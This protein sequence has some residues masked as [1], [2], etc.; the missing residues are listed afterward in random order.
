MILAALLLV[1]APAPDR[2]GWESGP[3]S[4]ARPAGF[5]YAECLW[6]ANKR[7]I[8]AALERRVDGGENPFAGLKMPACFQAP[9]F[10]ARF[11]VF[12][13][14]GLFF[15]RLYHQ[16][17]DRSPPVESFAAVAPVAYPIAPRAVQTDVARN[18]RGLVRIGDCAVRRAPAA[19]R[20]LLST[21]IATGGEAKAI[22]AMEPHFVA[23]QAPLTPVPFSAEMMR[24]TVAESLY[25]LSTAAAPGRGVGLAGRGDE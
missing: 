11:P 16:D 9:P 4:V 6:S 18:Y 8:R 15:E 12:V 2:D 10:A 7:A 21:R 17:F 19:A 20:A 25:R 23:C 1:A 13:L 3:P 14:R 24:G 5:A 22:A